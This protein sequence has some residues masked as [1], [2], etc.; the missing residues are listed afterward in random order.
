MEGWKENKLKDFLLVPIRNGLTKP[1]AIRGNGVKMIGMKEIFS[2][3]LI[4]S[5]EMDRVPVTER[6]Y[7]Y[8]SIQEN[9][10]LFARQSLTLEGAGKCAIVT[11]VEEPTVF[12]SHLIRLRIDKSKANPFY[13]FYYF[14]SNIGR[15][16]IRSLVQQVAA[17]GI[18][19]KELVEL[20][21]ITPPLDYQNQ[22]VDI[23]KSLDDK[24]ECNR[25]INE[26]L[27]QQAQALFKSWFVDFEPFRDKPFVESELGM[28]PEGWRVI[29]LGEVCKCVLGGTP[30]RS[31]DEY[32]NGDIPW[33]NSGEVNN[34][35]ILSPTEYITKEGLEKSATKL[36]P[37]HTTVLA[38]TG[39]T[40]GQVSLLEMES[41]ANQSVIGVLDNPNIPYSFIY[42]LINF[43]I[44]EL[45]SHMT[46]GA[47]QHIN[48]DNVEQL[49]IVL[50]PQ[51]ILKKYACLSVPLF[52][53]ISN[54]CF[55][56]ANLAK[57]RD[58]LL[59]RLMSGELK[60]QEIEES[61]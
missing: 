44:K 17:A 21:I 30:S 52:E 20:S 11:C 33:I 43:K 55:Q 27:E 26:N 14:K 28:I 60:V 15:N 40:L 18:R 19:G 25:R 7:E 59:P 56:S 12:E 13:I 8:S 49:K 45:M 32:W 53:K 22:I 6:E 38:I 39:A 31:H 36:L 5:V 24:I 57:T 58:T 47:Q 4:Q 48:K 9:D 16:K 1:S 50:P 35:R 29:C 46:G 34:F 3:D 41:C 10:L 42:P 23:L 51:Y 37:A 61:L 2:M 54:S